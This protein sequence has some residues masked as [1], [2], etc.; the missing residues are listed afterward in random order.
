MTY[1]I[2]QDLL[3]Q[4][5]D[6]MSNYMDDLQEV[7]AD[8]SGRGMYGKTCVGWVHE[9]SDLKFGAALLRALTQVAKDN[10]D[11]VNELLDIA[12]S[13]D[14]WETLN[15]IDKGRQDSMGMSTITYFPN[16]QVAS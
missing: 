9:V 8:Y 10:P 4:I 3:D 1:T 2:T 15:F 12:R 5:H 6:E 14:W 13:D 11:V 7:R 16:L